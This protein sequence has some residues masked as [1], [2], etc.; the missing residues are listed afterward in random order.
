MTTPNKNNKDDI[1][2]VPEE[3]SERFDAAAPRPAAPERSAPARTGEAQEFVE[4]DDLDLSEFVV[5]PPTASDSA[6][7]AMLTGSGGP[8]EGSR[9]FATPVAA[10]G[11]EGE[12]DKSLRTAR[13]ITVA[14]YRN[15][16][17]FGKR[18]IK[19]AFIQDIQIVLRK[20][21]FRVLAWA[22]MPEHVHFF[23]YPRVD[24]PSPLEVIKTIQQRFA[25]RVVRRWREIRAGVL[26]EIT[27]ELGSVHVWERVPQ[28]DLLIEGEDQ[29]RKVIELVDTK[30]VRRGLVEAPEH[31]NWS[32]AKR[33]AGDAQHGIDLVSF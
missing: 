11:D 23:M 9:A 1:Q 33:R 32:S 12:I 31:W 4:D 2:L 8:I 24:D 25:I 10:G 20:K 27:D 19:D 28:E 21:P 7:A 16:P 5:E 29:I 18:Q 14:C 3:D 30:P 22:V 15:L 6:T 17:L 13:L 26:D